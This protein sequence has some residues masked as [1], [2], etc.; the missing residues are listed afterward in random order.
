MRP[1]LASCNGGGHEHLCHERQVLATASADY[2]YLGCVSFVKQ[3]RSGTKL[4]AQ[5][6]PGQDLFGT[7]QTGLDHSEVA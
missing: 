1:R 7:L 5:C 4:W 3:V 6:K 2:M